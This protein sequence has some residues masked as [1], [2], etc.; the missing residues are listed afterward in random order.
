MQFLP[1]FPHRRRISKSVLKRKRRPPRDR[2]RRVSTAPLPEES[3]TRSDT[4]S[5]SDRSESAVTLA[6]GRTSVALTCADA[7]EK[8][9]HS[10]PSSS[11]QTAVLAGCPFD[12]ALYSTPLDPSRRHLLRRITELE[13]E[14]AGLREKGL[15]L[16]AMKCV[17]DGEFLD[18]TGFPNYK[19]FKLY[20]NT[21]NLCI[22]HAMLER[23]KDNN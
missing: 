2:A 18:H 14:M 8:Q 7:E 17:P 4:D 3:E 22:N 19:V 9:S 1:S 16:E 13:N 15:P 11:T 6:D 21:F 20:S 12:H 10:R 23:Q 5:E